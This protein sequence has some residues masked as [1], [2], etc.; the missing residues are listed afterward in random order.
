MISA[1]NSNSSANFYR[2]AAMC[3]AFYVVAQVVQEVAFHYG[4]NDSAAG[5]QA[6][7]QRLMR[8]DQFRLTVLLLSFFA[9]TVAFGAVT[10][11]RWEIRPAASLLGFAFT[12]LFVIGEI[13]NRSI[14]FFVIS[15]RWAAEYQA[16]ASATAKQL[17]AER[18]EIWNESFVGYYFVLRMGLFL[19]CLCFA[20]ATWDRSKRWNQIVAMAFAAN[21]ARVGGRIAEG[22]MGQGWLAPINEAVY[23]PASVLIYST[24]AVWL[25][26]QASECTAHG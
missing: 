20:V 3:G 26:R 9:I 23:F 7:L 19:G 5:E 6:I 2:L 11:R 24:L 17:I 4:I 25:W 13:I 8:L 22:F 15:E 21:A 18:I 14:D 16:A 1:N 12:F 10:L